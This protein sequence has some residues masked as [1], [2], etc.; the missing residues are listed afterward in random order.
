MGFREN[1]PSKPLIYAQYKQF[2]GT[3]G[4]CK[5]KSSRQPTASN[6]TVESVSPLLGIHKNQQDLPAVKYIYRR[7]TVKNSVD[8]MLQVYGPLFSLY[9][10]MLHSWKLIL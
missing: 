2:C 6:S 1:P 4:L 8:E 7:K 5:A 10:D 3:G 9:L